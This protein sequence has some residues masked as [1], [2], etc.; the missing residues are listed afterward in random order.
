MFYFNPNDVN[1]Q[2]FISRNLEDLKNYLKSLP[3]PK[4]QSGVLAGVNVP[5]KEAYEMINK[6][7][8]VKLQLEVNPTYVKSNQTKKLNNN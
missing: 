7:L 6:Y 5:T 8:V 2:Q 4:P 3:R 1:I